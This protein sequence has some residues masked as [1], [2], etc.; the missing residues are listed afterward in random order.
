MTAYQCQKV[1]AD[2]VIRRKKPR[3]KKESCRVLGV[4]DGDTIQVERV[5]Y[6]WLGLKKDVYPAKVRLAYIDTPELRTREAGAKRAK[7]LLEKLLTGKRVW[8]EYEQ[9]PSGRARTG[10]YQRILAV[11]HLQRTF[12]PNLN[13]NHLLLKQGIARLYRRPDNITP[14]HWKRLM[15]AERHA[16]RR[17]VGLWRNEGQRTASALWEYLLTGILIG[18]LTGFI[19][20]S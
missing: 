10:D 8:L 2:N 13:V 9:L 16:Q 18:I 14:H 11:V 3:I 1:V 20:A 4:Y 19:L 17:R 15:R 7:A 12:L 6:S 5:R